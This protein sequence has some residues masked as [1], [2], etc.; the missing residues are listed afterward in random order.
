[1]STAFEHPKADDTPPVGDSDGGPGSA[2]PEAITTGKTATR[3]W[4]RWLLKRGLF[5]V[6]TLWLV[7]L[8]VFLSTSALGDPV[9]AILGKD[10]AVSPDRVALI[11]EALHLDQPVIQRYFTWLGDL[12][13]G[14]PGTSVVN[15]IGVGEVIGG[16][17]ANSAFLVL[18]V[19]VL[20][21]PM[22]LGLAVLSA[23]YR[24]GPIDNVIR[25]VTLAFAG[26]PEFVTGIVLV[27]LFSTSILHILPAVTVLPIGSMAWDRPSALVLPVATLLLAIVPYLTRILRSNLLEIVDSDYVN[28]HG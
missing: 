25:F 4:T 15:G 22:A 24:G 18:V 2:E 1:M 19:A 8:I 28:S 23:R 14:D 12:L 20:M 6:L 27:A 13:T 7:S 5:A 26:V 9:R 10:F 11:R 16:K 21:V 17:V 3:A